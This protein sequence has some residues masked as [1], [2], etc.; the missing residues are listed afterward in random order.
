M[1]KINASTAWKV[2]KSGT[3]QKKLEAFAYRRQERRLDLIQALFIGNG[4]MVIGNCDNHTTG[5]R[6]VP[7]SLPIN[8]VRRDRRVIKYSG[9][10]FISVA[11]KL[12]WPA[13]FH[14]ESPSF[15]SFP[16]IRKSNKAVAYF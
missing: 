1:E 8:Y 7:R 4:W 6:A 12:D 9:F 3:T 15:W 13:M 5:P 16:G 2:D 14:D 10:A 11:Q